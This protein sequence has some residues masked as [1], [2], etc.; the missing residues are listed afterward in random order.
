MSIMLTVVITD[1]NRKEYIKDS[2]LS[3]LNQTLN[4]NEYEV[5]VSKTY[6]NNE[7]DEFLKEKSVTVSTEENPINNSFLAKPIEIS[8][9]KILCFLDDD[10][11]F[12]PWKLEFV[13]NS[14][15]NNDRLGYIKNANIGF[16]D[17]QIPEKIPE[18]KNY[19]EIYIKKRK[20][21]QISFTS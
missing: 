1:F 19:S 11:L 21:K 4:K 17:N 9:G 13:A 12:T 8:S 3:A 14:F 5:I 2:T 6:R 7:I 15:N 16:V 20:R 18:S 10:D